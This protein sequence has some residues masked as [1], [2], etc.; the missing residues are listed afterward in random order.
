MHFLDDVI[1]VLSIQLTQTLLCVILGGC[2]CG[3]VFSR[4]CFCCLSRTHSGVFHSFLSLV[5]NHFREAVTFSSMFIGMIPF[6]L[7]WKSSTWPKIWGLTGPTGK[8]NTWLEG[9]TLL[10]LPLL[11]C[12]FFFHSPLLQVVYAQQTM[13]RSLWSLRKPQQRSFA[14]RQIVT[15][16]HLTLVTSNQ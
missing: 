8:K 6:L 9:I 7:P 3:R 4:S 15:L 5:R 1:L 2:K 12:W 14:E 13:K 10:V 11:Y 16:L